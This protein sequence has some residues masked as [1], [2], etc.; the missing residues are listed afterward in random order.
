MLV[1]DVYYLLA[2]VV[3]ELWS[4]RNNE[5]GL[6][7]TYRPEFDVSQGCPQRVLQWHQR[8]KEQRGRDNDKSASLTRFLARLLYLELFL[9]SWWCTKDEVFG[10]TYIPSSSIGSMEMI[11]FTFY[12]VAYTIRKSA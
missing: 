11:K 12:R 1:I 6:L 10:C 5:T 2:E 9:C 8:C 4:A 7:E 3:Y